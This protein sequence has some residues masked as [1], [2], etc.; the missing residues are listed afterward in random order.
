[1]K[2]NITY[3]DHSGF[4]MELPHVAF[5]FDFY[6]GEIPSTPKDKPMVVF[7]SHRHQDHYN[8]QIFELVKEY[9]EVYFVL[10]KGV[11][12]KRQIEKYTALGVDLESHIILIKKNVTEVLT[13]KSGKSVEITTFKSTDEGVAFL[14]TFEGK[15]IYHAGDLNQ[16]VWEGESDQYNHNMRVA[17]LREMTKLDK[18]EIDVAFVP[19]DPRLETH[20]FEGLLVFLEHAAAKNVYPMHFWGEFQIISKFLEKYPE[21]YD[22][23]RKISKTGQFFEEEL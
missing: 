11:P 20:A 2:T 10:A 4:F 14:L 8:P 22:T 21:Y 17:Y 6:Q 15:R 19:L 3:I 16:W 18:A 7:V 23:I 5:L 12:V 1:M 13:L 9:P